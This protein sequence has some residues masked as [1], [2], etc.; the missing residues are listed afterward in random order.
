MSQ[1]NTEKQNQDGKPGY[2]YVTE[3]LLNGYQRAEFPLERTTKHNKI[4]RYI[5]QQLYWQRVGAKET[6]HVLAK[7]ALE[8]AKEFPSPSYLSSPD[9]LDHLLYL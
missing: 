1:G 4:S 6:F 8:N 5:E 7:V 2:K 3:K 9:Y